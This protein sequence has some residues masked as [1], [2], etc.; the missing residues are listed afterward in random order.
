[1]ALALSSAAAGTATGVVPNPSS[2]LAAPDSHPHHRQGGSTRF[3]VLDTYPEAP[4]PSAG[5]NPQGE[6]V[7]F[8]P[9]VPVSFVH[10]ASVDQVI[11]PARSEC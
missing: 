1:M 8:L 2:S 4:W 10:S 5:P 11:A 3:L 7:F 6:G 9:T